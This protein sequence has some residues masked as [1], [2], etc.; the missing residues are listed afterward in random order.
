MRNVIFKMLLSLKL[1][2]PERYFFGVKPAPK[3]T[4]LSGPR[5]D[6]P[7]YP[8]NCKKCEDCG[9]PATLIQFYVRTGQVYEWNVNKQELGE[10]LFEKENSDIGGY[11]FCDDCCHYDC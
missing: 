11:Y 7:E 4:P 5:P 3:G 6:L 9:K 10:K 2:S 8:A 1:I